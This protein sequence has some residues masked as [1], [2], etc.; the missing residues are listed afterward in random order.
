MAL[1][2]YSVPKPPI[3]IQFDYYI[4]E[5]VETPTDDNKI[6]TELDATVSLRYTGN[7]GFRLGWILF[8][9]GNVFGEA[10]EKVTRYF[11]ETLVQF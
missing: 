6:G 7:L 8:S 9:P 4:F 2:I 3:T 11:L 10:T 5:A 1:S